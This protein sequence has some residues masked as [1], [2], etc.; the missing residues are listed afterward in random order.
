MNVLSGAIKLFVKGV[1]DEASKKI[2][3]KFDISIEEASSIWDDINLDL[4]T[5][6]T[7]NISS[8]KIL[9]EDDEVKEN[10]KTTK[11]S[12]ATIKKKKDETNYEES[13]SDGCMH[14][15]LRGPRSGDCC[16]EKISSKSQTGT[17]CIK[18][19]SHEN[20]TQAEKKI[21]KKDTCIDEKKEAK[22]TISKNKFDNYCHTPS[23]LVFR[24]AQEKVV[25]GRQDSDGD[26][27]P[28]TEEDIEI[29]KK[30]KFPIAKDPLIT[31]PIK[32]DDKKEES[33]EDVEEELDEDVE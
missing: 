22:Y 17:Y 15:L 33:D 1:L 2:S 26:I 7:F 31:I 18:H 16:G 19:I 24:S 20:K 8:K 5:I 14:K 4:D 11:K 3:E 30:Y 9:Q 10:K 32:K 21:S 12:K 13:S 28:L 6:K 27:H 25:Y 29:C 23:G